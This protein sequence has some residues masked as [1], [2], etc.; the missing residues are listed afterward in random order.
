MAFSPK[1]DVLATGCVDTTVQLWDA[2]T[3]ARLQTL[4]GHTEW[5]TSVAFNPKGSLLASGGADGTVQLW[6]MT[7]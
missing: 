7:E 6:I 2:K 3:G 1:G 4:K 5:V